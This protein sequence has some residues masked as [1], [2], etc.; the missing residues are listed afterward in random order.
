MIGG[1]EIQATRLAKEWSARGHQVEIWTRRLEVE[2]PK[3][4]LEGAVRVRRLGWATRLK[5]LRVRRLE[6]FHFS[7]ALLFRLISQRHTYDVVLTQQALYPA[8]VAAVAS[9]LTGRPLVVRIASTGVTNDLESWGSLTDPVIGLLRRRVRALIVLNEQGLKEAHSRGFSRDRLHRIPNGIEPGSTPKLRSPTERPRVVYVGGFRSEK[10]V[11]LLLRAWRRSES[12]GELLL[13]GDGHLRPDLENLAKQLGVVPT[14]LGNVAEP[15]L[16]LRDADVFV[17]AS[18]AEGMS[19]ALLEAMAEGCACL[20]TFIGG[21]VDCLAPGSVVAPGAGEII[22]G[23][24]GWLV[25]CGDEIAMASA[26][27]ALCADAGLR[28]SLGQGA[29]ESVLAKYPLARSAKAYITVFES[30]AG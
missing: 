26:L 17:L 20:A 13:A 7:L 10:R 22:K 1:S 29:R 12:P 15:R 9:W 19:N 2:H 3:V 16:L 30:L 6:K 5:A 18:D 11:D 25:A 21:N 27:K 4:E 23:T 14:F 24:A 28:R 8:L